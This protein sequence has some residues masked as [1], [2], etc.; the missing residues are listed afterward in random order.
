MNELQAKIFAIR[1]RLYDVLVASPN[2][3]TGGEIVQQLGVSMTRQ[4]QE[5]GVNIIQLQTVNNQ[6][7]HGIV[8][9]LRE[10]DDISCLPMPAAAVELPA[11]KTVCQIEHPADDNGNRE[12]L[13]ELV[14]DAADKQLALTDFMDMVKKAYVCE[15]ASR[16]PKG[17]GMGSAIATSLGCTPSYGKTLMNKYLR[18]R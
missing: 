2:N 9:A 15:V 12:P 7:I 11:S 1:Q 5:K 10:I 16:L 13:R 3:N 8:D 4:V 18:N 14:K 6:V 17:R